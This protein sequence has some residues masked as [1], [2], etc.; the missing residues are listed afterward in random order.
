MGTAI[1]MPSRFMLGKRLAAHWRPAALVFLVVFGLIAA[2]TFILPGKYQT[3]LKILV[4]NERVDP[5]VGANQQT[6][7]ILYLDEV[8]EARINTEIELLTSADVLREVVRKC[9]LTDYI[10]MRGQPQVKREAAAV[11]RLQK[12]LTVTPVLKSN[13]IEATYQSTN[14]Q[15]AVEVLQ[16]LS[17]AY[18]ESHLRLHGE[19]GSY[20][21]FQKLSAK[22]S[23][24]L[25]DAE[26]ELASFK[27]AHSIL[28]LPAEQ[29]LGLQTVADLQRQLEASAVAAQKTGEIAGHLQKSV[30]QLPANVEQERRSI[31]NQNS[32]EQLSTL[33]VGFQNKR[34]EAVQRY[35]P[36]DRIIKEL[37]Q[38]I[39]HT[40]AAL[41]AAK[42][43]NAEE[44][45]MGANPTLADAQSAYIRTAA[46]H[47]GDQAQTQE[48]ARQLHSERARLKALDAESVT[49]QNLVRKVKTL[50]DLDDSYRKRSDEAHVSELLDKQRISNV[51]VVEEP[52]L[53]EVP[54]SPRRG[55]I[56][57]LGFFWSL[58]LG[59]G[60]A[61]GL[62]FL[63]DRIH[64][65]F[66]LEQAMGMPLLAAV[67][68]HAIA[69]CYGG[70]FPS[71]YTSM[72]RVPE[73][74]GW[75][76]L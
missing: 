61:L 11:R 17:Q 48:L 58:L 27:R 18:M 12:D 9:H 8:S 2:I 65:T 39:A 67:P 33:L 25:V 74:S 7:G 72:Q 62:D 5:L 54:S 34:L 14:P 15:R 22:Y 75:R 41:T 29:T 45:D 3:H 32:I 10:G 55:L 50:E 63:T 59:F 24:L 36:Q 38:E 56:L 35:R 21:F 26:N 46:D 52:F 40:Q 44:V 42:G 66:E 76:S 60:V 23:G 1:E 37:D 68:A 4:K 16:A 47:A 51:A 30:E 19:P 28:A 53:P 64:S 70:A 6:Q 43:S 71:L 69:P 13:V 49:Y 73:P 57:V 20:E 31:P